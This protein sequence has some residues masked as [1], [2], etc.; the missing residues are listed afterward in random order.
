MKYPKRKL[1]RNQ[2]LTS[3]GFLLMCQANLKRSKSRQNN[4]KR[5][6]SKIYRKNYY[7]TQKYYERVKGLNKSKLKDRPIYSKFLDL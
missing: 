3:M 7:K 4:Y 2:R 6:R 1:L 5:N